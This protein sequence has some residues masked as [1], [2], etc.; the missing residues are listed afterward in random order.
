MDTL[1]ATIYRKAKQRNDK[2]RRMFKQR[3][4]INRTCNRRVLYRTVSCSAV[5]YVRCAFRALSHVRVCRARA[6]P[7]ECRVAPCSPR[8][9]RCRAVEI[10]E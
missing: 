8:V 9:R 10:R 5:L 3:G 4:K 1:R 2:A 7:R 6:A